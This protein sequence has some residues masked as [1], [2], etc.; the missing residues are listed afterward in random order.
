LRGATPAD[1]QF[2]IAAFGARPAP[3]IQ[4]DRA[5]AAFLA[6]D[7]A[8][9]HALLASALRATTLFRLAGPA[10]PPLRMLAI[11][12]PG[13]L[14]ANTPLD[15]LLNPRD[16]GLDL[17]FV[18]PDH[19]LPAF[20]PPHDIA[21]FAATETSPAALD[22]LAWLH[23]AWHRPV[24]NNPALLPGLRRESLALA[25][26]ECPWLTTPALGLF[27]RAAI[28]ALAEG[29]D[30]DALLP[31]AAY[32][33]LLRPPG[34]HAGAGLVRVETPAQLRAALAAD[35]SARFHLS[36]FT[37]YRSPDGYFRKY[38]I[39]FID[40]AP[41]LCHLAISPHWMVHY[42]NAGME[43]DAARRAEEATEFDRFGTGF[44]RRHEAA[45]AALYAVLPFDYLVIDC[46][47]LPDGRLLVFEADT[48]AIVHN[49]DPPELYPY[50][51]TPMRA[52][53]AAFQAMLARRAG[54]FAA[55]EP[56]APERAA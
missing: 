13:D 20:L 8:Q 26:P 11:C 51:H 40:R 1:L 31:G 54:R 44:A 3:A 37:D 33:L 50:K 18:S 39:A 38:R 43:A 45:F 4:V 10:S 21:F 19:P 22:Q 2:S 24:L 35:A 6:F 46:A 5:L 42:L 28:A 49:L 16:V 23:L 17:L 47:E 52:L 12:T 15:F 25:L 30:P 29:Q 48:A 7:P 41:Y 27:P 14:M 56:F 36:A 32:P 9:G 53:S 55:T 34:S